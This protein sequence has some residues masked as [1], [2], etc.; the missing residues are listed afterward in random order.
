MTSIRI[1]QGLVAAGFALG[2]TA[3]HAMSGFSVTHQQEKQINVGMA[4]S[5]V[6]AALG[7]PDNNVHYG[8][9]PGRTFTYHVT[10]DPE[11]LFDVDFDADGKV[12]STSEREWLAN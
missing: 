10:G 12:L 9:E 11:V 1:S 5:D 3:A 4:Q 8:S 6:L 7:T 2:L